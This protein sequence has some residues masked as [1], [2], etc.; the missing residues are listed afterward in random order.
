MLHLSSDEGGEAGYGALLSVGL[1]AG[2]AYGGVVAGVSFCVRF[3][4]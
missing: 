2:F 4:H 1:Y 3:V